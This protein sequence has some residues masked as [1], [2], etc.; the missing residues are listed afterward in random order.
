L[1]KKGWFVH[2]PAFF[3]TYLKDSSHLCIGFSPHETGIVMFNGN[4]S[5]P[6][7]QAILILLLIILPLWVYWNVQ[8]FYFISYDDNLYVT[9]NHLTQSGLTLQGIITAFKDTTTTNWHPLTMISH[10]LDWEL[11]GKNAGGHHWSSLIIHII[12]TVLLFLLLNQMTGAIWRSAL[13]AALFAVHP[14]NVESV[15][16]VAERKNVLSTFFWFLTMLFYVGYARKPGWKRYLPVFLCFALGLMSKPM[17]V[18]LPF[19]LLLLDYWPLNRISLGSENIRQTKIPPPFKAAKVRPA[20]LIWEKI[21]LFA[22]S[23]VSALLTVYAAKSSGSIMTLNIL[24]FSNRLE[25][26]ILSYALYLKKLF[27]P[28]D[29]AVFYPLLDVPLQQV[30]LV[31]ILLIFITVLSCMYYKRHPYL[32]VGWFWFLGTLVPVIGIVQVGAQSMADRYAYVP[33]IGLFIGAIWLIADVV[34]GRM[35]QKTAVVLLVSLFLVLSLAAHRQAGYWQN[36]LMLFQRAFVVTKEKSV[37]SNVMIV[38]GNELIKQGKTDEAIVYF[39]QALNNRKGIP[40][41]YEALVSLANALSKKGK[42]TEAISL[43]LQ[44]LHINP[45]GHDAFYRLGAVYLETGRVDDALAAYRKALYLNKDNPLYHGGLGNA[46]FAAGKMAEAAS[47]YEKV[48]CIQPVNIEAHN[49]LGIVMMEQ[50]SMKDAVAYFQKSLM[51]E[52]RQANINFYLYKIFKKMGKDEGAANYYRK[53]VE[54]D[55]RFKQATKEPMRELQ[56]Q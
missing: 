18:T 54:L 6:Q 40:S 7:K 26:A 24:P 16:W 9:E 27:W 32:I 56:I 29:L 2:T 55:P 50:G 3:I 47:E 34:R 5:F 19:V 21:P 31:G 37:S 38:L 13:V 12:N 4:A 8:H 33:F 11:F 28:V 53:A 1:V 30:L 25:N 46:F 14:I 36:T 44:A 51:L 39:H 41:D 35:L 15:A 10:M 20:F 42:K 23:A 45:G 49:N 17:L 43:F 22:L 48:L 52:P